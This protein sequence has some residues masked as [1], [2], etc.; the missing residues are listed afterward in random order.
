MRSA[1]TCVSL[2]AAV[3]FCSIA[4]AS[5]FDGWSVEQIKADPCFV[6][7]EQESGLAL[8]QARESGERDASLCHIWIGYIDIDGDWRI[9]FD[10][11]G[12]GLTCCY[13]DDASPWLGDM[14]PLWTK[15]L[16][17]RLVEEGI[18]DGYP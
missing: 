15:G 3:F 12:Y 14:A 18:L 11:H 8:S 2:A 6:A 5:P 7:L 1:M 16:V 13:Q 17:S 4:N 9:Y 10:H